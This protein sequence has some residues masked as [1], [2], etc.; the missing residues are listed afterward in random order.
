VTVLDCSSVEHAARCLCGLLGISSVELSRRVDEIEVDWNH[1]S[2]APDTQVLI[3]FGVDPN[4]PPEPAAVRWFHA[5]RA[6]PGSRFQKGLLPTL[7]AT[8]KLW[9]DLGACAAAW[10]SE[11]DWL[12]YQHSFSR[13][14]RTYSSQFRS[15]RLARGWEGPF[16]FLVKDAALNRHRGHKD[17]TQIC[18]AAEDICADFEEVYGQSLRDAYVASTRPCLVVFTRPGP[19]H[20]AVRAAAN[21][22]FRSHRGIDCGFDCNT[23]FSGKGNPVPFLWIDAVEWP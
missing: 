16:A 20:G 3:Q 23:N 15:K 12:K 1:P 19:W 10:L 8:P 13:G 17:F 6:V 14:D 22:V 2:V 11:A 4:A 18:E 7:Q 9:G 21:Y 5:T